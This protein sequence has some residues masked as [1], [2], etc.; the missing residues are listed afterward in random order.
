VEEFFSRTVSGSRR[1]TLVRGG[2]GPSPLIMI[3]GY[4][5]GYQT[6]V[7]GIAALPLKDL[8]GGALPNVPRR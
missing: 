6:P 5:R 4:A 8:D 2:Y 7:A 3:R 1:R